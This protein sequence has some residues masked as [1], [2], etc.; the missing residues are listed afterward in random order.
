MPPPSRGVQERPEPFHMKPLEFLFS[1]PRYFLLHDIVITLAVYLVLRWALNRTL[2]RTVKDDEMRFRV[3][4]VSNYVL[5]GLL[6]V[7]VAQLVAQNR[8]SAASFVG[9]LSAGIA[10]VFREPI[11]NIAGW[12][13]IIVRKPF[14]LGDRVQIDEHQAGDVIDIGLHDFSILEIGNWVQA[15]QSTGRIIHVP[16]SVIFTKAI[17]NYHQGFPYLWHELEVAITF[18][19][20][21]K[22]ALETLQSIA[23]SHTEVSRKEQAQVVEELAR[24]EDYLIRFKHLTPIV[25]LKKSDYALVLTVRYCCDPRAR[26]STESALWQLILEAFAEADSIEL[27]Y[28]TQTLKGDWSL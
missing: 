12:L 21:W 24:Q 8:W 27:A 11:L 3:G 15:D 2:Q 23:S 9:L 22:L 13:F 14:S 4:K 7:V 28:P 5:K 26:R 25:Y 20:D 1:D 16:N 19:S 6:L 18:Q 17:A 10:F